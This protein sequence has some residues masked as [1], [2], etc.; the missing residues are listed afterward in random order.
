MGA[1]IKFQV[2]DRDFQVSKSEKNYLFIYL[3]FR[4]TS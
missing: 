3:S 1:K 2:P 4:W